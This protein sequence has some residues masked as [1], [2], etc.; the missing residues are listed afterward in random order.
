MKKQ[1]YAHPML[2]LVHQARFMFSGGFVN[3]QVDLDA[4]LCTIVLSHRIYACLIITNIIDFNVLH[5]TIRFRNILG[6][7]N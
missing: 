4:I 6:Q 3:A 2:I 7:Q 1:Y 5:T